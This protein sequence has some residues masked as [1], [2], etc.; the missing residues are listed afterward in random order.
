MNL[1]EV[2]EFR[3]DLYFEGAVKIDWFYSPDKS[4][5]VAEN[6]VFQGNEYYGVE[7]RG[8]EQKKM[9]DTIHFV[10]NLTE[11]LSDENSNPLS[12]AIA[13]YGTGKSHLAVTMAQIFSGPKYMPEV[14]DKVINNIATID[15]D[16]ANFI[17]ENTKGRNFV[18]VL[19]GMRDF[20]LNSEI[21]RSV[22]KSLDLYGIS[23]EFLIKVNTTIKTAKTF[24]EINIKKEPELFIKAAKEQGWVCDKNNIEAKIK[25]SI[26][27]D[28][29]LTVINNVYKQINGQEIRWD[30]GIDAASI[31][32]L[33]VSELCGINGE[34]DHI[35]ILFDEFGRYLEYAS[36]VNNAAK[37]GESALQQIYEA[38][39]KTENAEGYIQVINFIQSDIKTY[40]QRVDKTTNIG[41]YI[42]RYDTSDKYYISSNLETVFANLIQR[43]NKDVF[44]KTIVLWQKVEENRWKNLFDNMNRWLSTNG[45]WSNYSK[46]RKAIVEG[47]YPMHPI[48]TYMLTNLSDYLQN[49]SSLTL[50]SRYIEQYSNI[51]ID[52]H[53]HVMPENLISGELF[54]EMLSAEQ[55]GRKKTQQCIK[56]DTVV[57]KYGDKLT[58]SALA[59]LRANLVL[60]ILNFKTNSREDAIL[61]LSTCSGIS[62]AEINK[63]FE[64]IEDNYAI[65]EFDEY[66]NVFEFTEN[67]VGAHDFK[68]YKKRLLAN[69]YFNN[70]F[71]A[72]PKIKELTGVINPLET[73]FGQERHINTR[74]WVFNQDLYPIEDFNRNRVDMYLTDWK[75]AVDITTPK[76]KLT[77]LYVNKD[78]ED[79]IIENAQ[80]MVSMF[81][82]KPIVVMLLNDVEN[83][84]C[85]AIKEYRA[86]DSIPEDDQ[87]KFGRHYE[88]D[89]E[90]TKEK[91]VTEINNLKKQR[92]RITKNGIVQVEDR[93][94]K[95]LTGVFSDIYKN[96]VPFHVDKF[97][98][99]S[100]NINNKVGSY[101]C[102]ILKKIFDA[103]SLNKNV[104]SSM[105]PEE[106]SRF[107]SLLESPATSWRCINTEYKLIP[108]EEKNA[109][110]VYDEIVEELSSQKEVNCKDIYDRYCIP[111]YGMNEYSITLM[112]AIICGNFN[113]C[114]RINQDGE[115]KN[116]NLWKDEIITGDNKKID[117]KIIKSSTLI[118]VDTDSV[119]KKY[120][121]FFERINKNTHISKVEQLEQELEKMLAIDEVPTELET[122]FQLAKSNLNKGKEI[123]NK[124][125]CAC[126]E[127]DKN[128]D[129][130]CEEINNGRFEIFK[131]VEGLSKIR[132]L[133][134]NIEKGLIFR[135]NYKFDDECK[136]ELF[137]LKEEIDSF[138]LE[139]IDNYVLNMACP[140]IERL[141]TFRN[142]NN[143]IL[144]MLKDLGKEYENYAQKIERKLE[145]EL[146]NRAEIESRQ[147]LR[148]D[149][150]EYFAK[151]LKINEFT[152]Y[153]T[154][155]ELLNNGLDIW[156]RVEKHGVVLGN[157]GPSIKSDLQ[158]SIT[159]LK[160]KKDE[161]KKLLDCVW[162]DF[163]EI[164]SIEAISNLVNNIRFLLQKG[165]LKK[166]QDD[167][168]E[169]N[170]TLLNLKTDMDEIKGSKSRSQL[171][172]NSERI[173][174][175]Y[176]ELELDIDVTDIIKGVTD[177][178]KS[179]FDIK[180]NEWKTKNLS[181]G[182]E[183][184]EAIQQWKQRVQIIPEY[185]SDETKEAVKNL[186]QKADKIISKNKID[187]IISCFDK[188]ED[189][190]K[191]ECLNRLKL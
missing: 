8:F 149:C 6:F 168:N 90:R 143:R 180:E 170:A 119:V 61:A 82:N 55:D 113:Y 11:K 122:K 173:K 31:L 46:F 103:N 155:D 19:N 83:K 117:L 35:I 71:I 132:E 56:Y 97:I 190:E 175:K 39:Q 100:N 163:Y 54:S 59:I 171:M 128:L 185:L 102:S 68:I 118:L 191:R 186:H 21:L 147:K 89:Y 182:N 131:A 92:F 134:I 52:T 166:D 63:E 177:S 138:L 66:A 79:L 72:D 32:N 2:L 187:Y 81:E 50:V 41:R 159:Q 137:G 24:F 84:V 75:K 183:S 25:E 184:I 49:R 67:S 160:N 43:K 145:K 48:S 45:I 58:E 111:P 14:Y 146:S 150:E 133:L 121:G 37:S 23:N 178:T 62:I 34:F 18:I 157:D 78:T 74:E 116:I 30:E 144:S 106:K 36:G 47:I 87:K 120:E 28:D 151:F 189:D 77:W 179:G 96:V 95:Y 40:L 153:A 165:L 3:K 181:L 5:K 16:S 51:D 164:N 172:S 156:N 108:P 105:I 85:D 93:L 53:P 86:L 4:A 110:Q 152:I 104:I 42:G 161:I 29:T 148:K 139:N 174:Q 158:N 112:I 99:S 38:T 130:A 169:L 64:V 70:S 26:F 17:R 13:D 69:M 20:N 123:K 27:E 127:I 101:Y 109:K 76:G 142:H 115:T 7:D 15:S 140:S 60:R 57:A 124:W 65:L 9:I 10:R 129:V 162:N 44:E 98:G 107:A 126:E 136:K 114:L 94:P 12:L 135:D 154:I 176:E 88:E 188:L 80:K 125:A 141:N 1:G 33:L 73:N 22:Q 167:L 91:V